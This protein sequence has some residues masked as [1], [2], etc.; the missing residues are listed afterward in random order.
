MAEASIN[1][2]LLRFSERFIAGRVNV[3]EAIVELRRKPEILERLIGEFDAA[4]T[5]LNAFGR[6]SEI[7]ESDQR[8]FPNVAKVRSALKD[9]SLLTLS[10]LEKDIS[11]T[12]V[13][14]AG[15]AFREADT[16]MEIGEAYRSGGADRSLP[17]WEF[18]QDIRNSEQLAAALM[19]EIYGKFTE[20]K[21]PEI[22]K[23]ER[24]GFGVVLAL[25][26][27][28]AQ[29]A[30]AGHRTRLFEAVKEWYDVGEGFSPDLVKGVQKLS[31]EKVEASS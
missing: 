4:V 12:T 26:E 20:E 11:F 7:S 6:G 13:L 24:R 8:L 5:Q 2:S 19:L 28:V 29:Q 1:E 16:L 30:I 27:I 21:F 10:D 17:K 18:H 14:K 23:L 22:A 25:E 9:Q 15:R 31:E 3:G